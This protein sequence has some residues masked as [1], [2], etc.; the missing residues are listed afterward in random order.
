VNI[1]D[2]LNTSI[3]SLSSVRS[4]VAGCQRISPASLH[5]S[6]ATSATSRKSS[7]QLSCTGQSSNK[8]ASSRK[9]VNENC[10]GNT[11]GNVCHISAANGNKPSV[12]KALSTG[13][14]RKRQIS[15]HSAL[16]LD[17]DDEFEDFHCSN[18]AK[19]RVEAA[20]SK[21]D[22][23]LAV[24]GKVIH[25]TDVEASSRQKVTSVL[26]GISSSP[27]SCSAAVCFTSS[28]SPVT[29]PVTPNG[30]SVQCKVTQRLSKFAFKDNVLRQQQESSTGDSVTSQGLS[31]TEQTA[32]HGAGNCNSIALYSQA[33]VCQLEF[34]LY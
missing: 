25:K 11:V 4:P 12:A 15:K 19:K 18:V 2:L 5:V 32:H 26:T 30:G 9:S 33:C 24:A 29:T 22:C 6:P 28:H 27:I 8:K 1:S 7:Q 20:E 34:Q 13:D 21:T 23:S 17:S 14:S 31:V 16:S 3:Q 10:R